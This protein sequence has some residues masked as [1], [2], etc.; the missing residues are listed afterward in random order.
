[1]GGNDE[2]LSLETMNPPTRSTLLVAVLVAACNR[3]PTYDLVVANGR[4]M[5]PQSGLDSVRNVGIRAGRVEAVSASP[6]MPADRREAAKAGI[7]AAKAAAESASKPKRASPRANH[8][9]DADTS[10]RSAS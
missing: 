3:A 1:M 6:S 9:A 2:P 8:S 4:V 7:E 10:L 5:D